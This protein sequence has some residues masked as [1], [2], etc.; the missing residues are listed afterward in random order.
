MPSKGVHVYTYIA[1]PNCRI[2]LS[3]PGESITRD[4]L[5]E[6]WDSDLEVDTKNIPGLLNTTG[7]FV[8]KVVKDRDTV[9]TEQWVQVNA[10]TGSL[11]EG[12]MTTIAD[13]PTVITDH[14]VLVSYGFYAAGPGHEILPNRHQCYI[15]VTPD[16]STWMGLVAGPNTAQGGRPFRKLV[17]PAAHDV[18]MNSMA[19]CNALLKYVGG[20]VVSTLISSDRYE[21]R[22]REVAD[23]VSGRAIA[24]LAPNIVSS[25]ALTQK[26]SVETMLRLGA[27]YFEFR[28]AY[29]H[30]QVRNAMKPVLDDKLYFQ[31]SA[32]PGMRYDVFLR[33][34]VRF[35]VQRGPDEMVVVQC[36]WDGIPGDCARPSQ[37]ELHRYVADALRAEAPD[38]QV[39]AGDLA[40]LRERTISEL[41][42]QK[43]RLIVTRDVDSLSTYTD[44]GY[45]TLDGAKL[46]G[47]FDTILVGRNE[48]GT[49]RAF[50]N[51]QCQA[52]PTAVPRAVA[53][54]VLSANATNSCLLAS[55]ASCDHKTLP[56]VRQNGLERCHDD[57]LVVIM[58][59]FFDGATAHVAI[60]L[61]RKR[62]R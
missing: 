20:A 24:A 14:G 54:S 52:T 38:G 28:P 59:D 27:R 41:R 10:L 26:D 62:L 58:N 48:A 61:S 7:R 43:K 3:V 55:K 23:A 47:A 2:E 12:T 1:V 8:F 57:T 16:Y 51:I 29:C 56:W 42:A 53:M 11:G 33:E 6:F 18:G 31:H 34:V 25:L 30:N 35:L 4:S 15:T 45:A 22:L 40:D 49:G 5:Y 46:L 21:A 36:R 9:L 39:V 50:V 60:E 44:E 13:T 37:E 19:T 32:I 17:L